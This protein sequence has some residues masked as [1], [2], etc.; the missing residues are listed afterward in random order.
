[1]NYQKRFKLISTKELTKD[2]VNGYKIFNGAKYFSVGIS[3]NHL[4]FKPAK[5]YIKY[6]FDTT[7]INS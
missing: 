2:L 6:F 4:V 7:R 1:M 5:K 3:Q